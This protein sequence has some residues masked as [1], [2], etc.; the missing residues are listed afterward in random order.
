MRLIASSIDHPE[1]TA[2]LLADLKAAA[3]F[4]ADLAQPIFAH[5][6]S[7]NIVETDRGHHTVWD[8]SYGGGSNSPLAVISAVVGHTK[9]MAAAARSDHPTKL[10]NGASVLRPRTS[11]VTAISIGTK[12]MPMA[13][14]PTQ[15]NTNES[16]DN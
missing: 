2:R 8:L 7:E 16:V 12:T 6:Q 5:L 13:D 4:E 9:P 3:P 10:D 14:D 11:N 15:R 1:K